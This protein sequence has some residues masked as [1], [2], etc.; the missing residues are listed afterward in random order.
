MEQS[1]DFSGKPQK[2]HF[3]PSGGSLESK[4]GCS[5][6]HLDEMNPTLHPRT[7]LDEF[8]DIQWLY[9]DIQ[10]QQVLIHPW[11]RQ[12]VS[13]QGMVN[14]GSSVIQETQQ[15]LQ[16][17]HLLAQTL[18][19]EHAKEKMDFIPQT[20]CLFWNICCFPQRKLLSPEP[21]IQKFIQPLD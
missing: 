7:C 9:N 18:R 4:S 12:G 13:D 1:H 20:S 16:H 21:S 15:E 17:F 10:D 2:G 3:S 8:M 11:M 14:L 5:C 6:T 19:G